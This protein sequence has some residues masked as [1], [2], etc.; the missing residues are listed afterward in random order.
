MDIFKKDDVLFKCASKPR[1]RA[2]SVCTN[3]QPKKM[4]FTIFIS[5]RNRLLISDLLVNFRETL[6]LMQLF[7][8][9][10]HSICE[11][12]FTKIK[13]SVAKQEFTIGFVKLQ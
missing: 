6:L 5:E 8:T 7:L 10:Y 4:R 12:R 2:R 9:P 11:C 13:H 3:M 1:V